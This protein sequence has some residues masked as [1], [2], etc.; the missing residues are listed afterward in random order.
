[1]DINYEQILQI[2]N[3]IEQQMGV[4]DL[5]VEEVNMKMAAVKQPVVVKYRK[6]LPE[7]RFAVGMV[8][9]HRRFKYTCVIYGWNE[10][11]AETLDW[12]EQVSYSIIAD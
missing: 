11:C 9:R 12:I 4:R 6:N 10:K 8:M 7:V 1:M 3:Q 2:S 5:F